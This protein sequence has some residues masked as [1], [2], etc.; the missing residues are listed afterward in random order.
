[1]KVADQPSANPPYQS[2]AAVR[3]QHP[4]TLLHRLRR[5]VHLAPHLPKLLAHLR[6][7]L[8]LVVQA[9]RIVAD[10]L[11]DLHGAEFRAAHGAE[12]RH[13]VGILG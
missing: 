13:L 4:I 12:A 7:A 5:H 3:L 1:M 8:L 6:H 11:R 10:V 9:R 2:S